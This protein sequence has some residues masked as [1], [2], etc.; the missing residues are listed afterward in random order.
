M[1]K[2][3][4]QEKRVAA[5]AAQ[6]QVELMRKEAAAGKDALRAAREHWSLQLLAPA[7]Q[8]SCGSNILPLCAAIPS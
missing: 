3:R 7:E 8:P 2:R 6:A 4:A 1:E 5:A